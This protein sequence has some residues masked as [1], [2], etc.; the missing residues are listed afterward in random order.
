[1]A[2]LLTRLEQLRSIPLPILGGI[3]GT[4]YG[5]PATVDRQMIIVVSVRRHRTF[6]MH[7][8]SDP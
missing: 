5:E 4:S 3:L 8:I 7:E 2:E 1:M 6:S